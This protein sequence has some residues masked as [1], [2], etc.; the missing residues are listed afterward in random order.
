MPLVWKRL[1]TPGYDIVVTSSHAFS[2]YFPVHD[3]IHL[4]YVYAPMRYAWTR[5]IDQR[6]A[7]PILR[8]ARSIAK[9]LDRRSTRSVA[10]FAGI[11]SAVVGR[12][13]R[14]Y[15]RDAVLIPP[16]VDLERFPYSPQITRN[17]FLL[18]VSRWVP[19]KRLDLVIAVAEKLGMPAVIAGHGPDAGR[20]RHLAREASVPVQICESPSDEELRVLYQTCELL[21]FPPEEDFGIVPVEAQACGAKV[22]ALARGGSV[23][24]VQDQHTG[25]LSPDQSVESLARATRACLELGDRGSACRR[26]AEQFSTDAFDRRFM[27]WIDQAAPR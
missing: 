12:I 13:R 8:P 1:R 7:S 15:D 14:F 26:Q 20:L 24:T 2:R 10:A 23:D 3:A 25:I 19:Y 5:Q 11:S 4:S 17:G 16:P 6:A 18:G 9:V 22:V 21:I 27:A